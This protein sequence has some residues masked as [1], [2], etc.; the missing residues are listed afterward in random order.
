M[1]KK[2]LTRWSAGLILGGLL[3]V[4]AHADTLK[5][6]AMPVGSGWYVA[7]AA[8]EKVIE[9]SV[10]DTD[11]EIIARGGGVANPMVV[12]QGKADIA[13][14][15]VATS[16]WATR[17]QL[18]YEGQE[19]TD[20]R[21][22]VGGLNPVY[23][24]AIVRNEYLKENGFSSLKE[25]LESD[26]AVNIMMKPPGSNIP[27][28]VD[29]VLKAHGISRADI[30]ARGGRIIQIDSSQMAP[31]M[32]DGRAD[33]YFDTVLRGHPT[34]QEIAL[35]AD[36]SFIDLSQESM[37]A[38]A[39]YGLQKGEIPQWFDIQDKPTLG[40]DFGTHLIAHK[41]LP[42]DVAYAITKSVVEHM[43]TLAAEFPAWKA[44]KLERAASPE[45]NGIPLHPGAERY[46]KEKGLL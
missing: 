36:V 6:G 13:L 9:A 21:S 26:K 7:A 23:I 30:E 22:L 40:G 15:N 12:Q 31:L 44:F 39:E 10:K 16:L 35:T 43:E 25:I 8:L 5:I 34:I 2:A 28:A 14:S 4:S 46:Y 24:G 41:N 45:T 18:L 20:I 17:G 3:S 42:D 38:L 32:R 27:P 33:L 19:A 29:I 1:I 37:D 11:V